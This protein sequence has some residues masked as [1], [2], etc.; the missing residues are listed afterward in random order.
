MSEFKQH[1]PDRPDPPE[2]RSSGPDQSVEQASKSTDD[3]LPHDDDAESSAAQS[4]AGDTATEAEGTTDGAAQLEAVAKLEGEPLPEEQTGADTRQ[5]QDHT[6]DSHQES[7]VAKPEGHPTAQEQGRLSTEDVGQG[8]DRAQVPPDGSGA[9]QGSNDQGKQTSADQSEC[10]DEIGPELRQAWEDS[11]AA[12][13][14]NRHEEGGYIIRE[15]D[16]SHGIER[17]PAGSQGQIDAPPRDADGRYNGKDV[18]GEFH[19]HPNPSS[20]GWDPAPSPGD[21]YEIRESEYPGDSYV[22]SS[23]AMYRIHPDGTWDDLGSRHDLI[24]GK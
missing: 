7:L 18:V 5:I 12:S 9:S 22:V 23:D 1:Q 14:T 8:H 13:E 20:E 4:E 3:V 15:D 24:G 2:A 17:W 10:L 6:D 16:G 21:I 19:T 11:D